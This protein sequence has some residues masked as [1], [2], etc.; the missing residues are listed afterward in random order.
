M[1]N[2]ECILILYLDF[3]E[4]I[5]I[6]FLLTSEARAFLCNNITSITC[7]I[8]RFAC[9]ILLAVK[10]I[11]SQRIGK[12]IQNRNVKNLNYSEYLLNIMTEY[13]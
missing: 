10:I 1:Y 6:I 13:H 11:N 9:A 3:F 8:I 4:I 2:K 5:D 12:K 7:C